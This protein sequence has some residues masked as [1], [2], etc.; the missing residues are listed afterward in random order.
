MEAEHNTLQG[1]AQKGLYT[2]AGRTLCSSKPAVTAPQLLSIDAQGGPQ[3]LGLECHFQLS[4]WRG[5][6]LGAHLKLLWA[7]E[8]GGV[9]PEAF[10]QFGRA[11]C[12]RMDALR[13]GGRDTGF[14]S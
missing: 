6:W 9:L 12:L 13:G 1:P 2:A 7:H 5:A 11:Y 10:G 3:G 4:M 14:Q 8:A